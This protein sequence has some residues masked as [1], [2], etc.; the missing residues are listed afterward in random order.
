MLEKPVETPSNTLDIH[1][2]PL[3]H[4]GTPQKMKHLAVGQN[5]VPPVTLKSLLKW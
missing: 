1:E 4:K 2:N 3:E 5:P